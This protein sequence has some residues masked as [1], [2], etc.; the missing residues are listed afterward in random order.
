MLVTD[1]QGEAGEATVQGYPRWWRQ[2][3]LLQ[4]DVTSESEWERACV[5]VVD[6]LGGLDI[7]VTNAGMGD[8]KSIKDTTLCEWAVAIDQTGVFLGMKIALPAEVRT[9]F[10]INISSIFGASGGF[11]VSP[12]YH[13]AKGTV[14]TL[15][16]NVA[17]IGPRRAFESTR[18]TR[19]SS[20]RR[21]SNRPAGPRSGGR[22]DRADA[23]G[24]GGPSRGH[25]G[26]GGVPR[27]RRPAFV[28][29]VELYIYGGY[30]AR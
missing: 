1:I 3:R 25:R 14:R 15:T 27:K 10:G 24:Q 6:D 4:D 20:Q 9:R 21:F 7:L 16:K 23:D 17:L 11:G 30:M 19:A 8:I 2:G 18:S 28:T 13:A 26:G 29:G 12:A 5:R 22:H